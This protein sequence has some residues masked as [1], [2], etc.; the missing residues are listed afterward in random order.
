[1]LAVVVVDPMY[2]LYLLATNVVG[3]NFHAVLVEEPWPSYV[4]IPRARGSSKSVNVVVNCTASRSL[5]HVWSVGLPGDKVMSQFNL[6]GSVAL[7]HMNNIYE[8]AE[9]IV[10]SSEL[11][12][13]RLYIN[14]TEGKNGTKIACVDPGTAGV[15]SATTLI[16]E[17][18][19]LQ[20]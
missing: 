13:I 9:I 15:I 18:I 7:L 12:T 11:K 2:T 10:E 14:N 5:H 20:K 3:L 6:T 17:L 16:G 1:M 4:F 8:M 19:L